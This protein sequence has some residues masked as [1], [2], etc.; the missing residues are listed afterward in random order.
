MRRRRSQSVLLEQHHSR[1]LGTNTGLMKP[2]AISRKTT[3]ATVGSDSVNAEAQDGS[4]SCNANMLTLVDG[5]NP[6]MQMYTVATCHRHATAIRQSRH[7]P[8]ILAW[9][10]HSFDG[11]SHR[12]RSRLNNS[13]Q[14]G[15]GWSDWA[16][17]VMTIEPGDMGTDSRGVGTWLFGQPPTAPASAHSPIAQILASTTSLTVKSV[18]KSCRT[19][20]AGVGRRS[21]GK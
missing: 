18:A 8:R 14:A 1:C 17:I 21:S 5:Q 11:W 9:C 10:F 2:A 12:L 3:M 13:E 6:R 16:G 7:C 19:E 20:L 4:G 15:E